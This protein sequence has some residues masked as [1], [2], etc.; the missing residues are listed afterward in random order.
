MCFLYLSVFL[1][2]I[3]YPV[4]GPTSSPSPEALGQVRALVGDWGTKL[5]FLASVAYLANRLSRRRGDTS[6][7]FGVFSGLLAAAALQGFVYL[8]FPPV[9]TAEASIFA[10]L[11]AV[12]G[13][14]GAGAAQRVVAFHEASRR[15]AQDLGRA[16]DTEDVAAVV[17]RAFCAALDPSGAVGVSVWLR[18]AEGGGVGREEGLVLRASW[19]ERPSSP[20]R[21]PALLA[22]EDLDGLDG[23]SVGRRAYTLS[24]SDVPEHERSR[25][26]A[27]GLGGAVVVPI[28]SRSDDLAGVVF[29]TRRGR[30]RLP[31]GALAE[32][33]T[34]G[35]QA[36]IVLE[37]LRL[38]AEAREAA[39]LRE[40]ARLS[41][42]LHD[43]VTQQLVAIKM[44]LE[45]AL[46]T[47]D[48]TRFAAG[49]DARQKVRRAAS[50]AKSGVEQSREMIWALRPEALER[51]HFSDVLQ[52]LAED[53]ARRMEADVEVRVEE[54]EATLTQEAEN[55]LYRV[56][57]E[58][59]T[60]AQRHSRAG[61]VRLTL[62][63]LDDVVLLDVWDDGVGFVPADRNNR[64]PRRSGGPSS[65]AGL[66][67]MQERVQGIGGSLEIESEP[68]R[69]TCVSV[70][71]PAKAPDPASPRVALSDNEPT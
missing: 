41:R 63:Y 61:H 52:G 50:Y 30:W 70:S 65:G 16:R 6:A 4:F 33:E 37:N 24:P 15:A 1:Y 28:R 35:V 38:V 32:L 27:Q 7:A 44:D 57:Q 53:V 14:F 29:F 17:G 3:F 18:A 40:R 60:N 5:V 49:G 69:G 26:P 31:R 39:T 62:A 34:V 21:P 43:T 71:A 47:E 10:A 51:A 68:G 9:V 25:W 2:V 42:D 58:A 48:P 8:V 22:L 59:L 67:S 54:G 23:L 13:Y 64:P 46:K 12:G 56:A 36:G 11:G 45:A 66:L 20:G 55:A 19:P